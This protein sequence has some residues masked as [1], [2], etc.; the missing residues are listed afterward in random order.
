MAKAR[1]YR[2]RG[3]PVTCPPHRITRYSPVIA[4]LLL[5]H[6]RAEIWDIGITVANCWGSITCSQHL[7]M[8]IHNQGLMGQS[9]DANPEAGLWRDMDIVHCLLGTGNFFVGEEIPRTPEDAFRKF[10]LQ[11]GTTASAVINRKNPLAKKLKN[12]SELHS[13]AGS[14]GIKDKDACPVSYM[15]MDRYLRNMGQVDW[16][17]EHVD[18]VI[19]LSQYEE[20]GKNEDGTLLLGQIDDLEKLREK[21]KKAAGKNNSNRKTAVEGARLRPE[22]LIRSLALALQAE[23]AGMMFPYLTMHRAAWAMLRAVK[24]ACHPLLRETVGPGY[25]ERDSQIPWVVGWVLKALDDGDSTLLQIA[26]VVVRA[27]ARTA[28]GTWRHRGFGG[29]AFPCNF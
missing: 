5:Y 29:W 28:H 12:F 11:M 14:R 22:E 18:K 27:R 1:A 19:S 3:E 26:A 17:P 7:Y 23:S 8:A 20:E 9:E 2:Q 13:K 4:G 25:M 6:F 10:C 21:R 15:F 24:E 16:T